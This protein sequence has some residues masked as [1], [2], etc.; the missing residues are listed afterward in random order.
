MTSAD[1]S[2]TYLEMQ[3]YL[4]N[5]IDASEAANLYVYLSTKSKSKHMW[6][7]PFLARSDAEK[8]S[9]EMKPC[10]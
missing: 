1:S 2:L 10:M 6:S 5:G 4:R 3:G 8:R 7:R 9:A